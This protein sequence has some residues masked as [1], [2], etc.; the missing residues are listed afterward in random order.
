[1][2]PIWKSKTFWLNLIGLIV[3]ALEAMNEPR[4]VEYTA[5][6]LVIANVA[7]RLVTNEG[8]T[9]GITEP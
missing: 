9:L 5:Y 3:V 4:Y 8:V 7:L 6:G 1:M 2:K